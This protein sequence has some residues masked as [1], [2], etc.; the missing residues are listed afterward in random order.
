M[1]SV[2]IKISE[3]PFAEVG[4]LKLSQDT[5]AAGDAY[6]LKVKKK[7][8]TSNSASVQIRDPVRTYT[9]LQRLCQ[10]YVGVSCNGRSLNARSSCSRG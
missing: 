2:L 5:G 6:I 7:K 9:L 1:M 4:I 3:Q 8:G 10:R